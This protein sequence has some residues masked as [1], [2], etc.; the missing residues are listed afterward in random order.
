MKGSTE[1]SP[2]E[3][4]Q[5]NSDC[6]PDQQDLASGE[7]IESLANSGDLAQE[8]TPKE[9]IGALMDPYDPLG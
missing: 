3:Q 5:F 4:V 1:E 2:P 9:V 6:H 8:L 7:V